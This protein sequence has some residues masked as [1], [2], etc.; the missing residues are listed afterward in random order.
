MFTGRG[1]FGNCIL[2]FFVKLTAKTK[3]FLIVRKDCFADATFITDLDIVNLKKKKKRLLVSIFCRRGLNLQSLNAVAPAIEERITKQTLIKPA[4]LGDP[5]GKGSKASLNP[6]DEDD[7]DNDGT[8]PF[9]EETEE[10][11]PHAEPRSLQKGD[12]LQ[13]TDGDRKVELFFIE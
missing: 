7:D 2:K 3:L 10:K 8:N 13:E 6:F 4:A 1:S 9:I 12:N 11:Q 5:A